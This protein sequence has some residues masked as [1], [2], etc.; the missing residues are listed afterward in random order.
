M[1]KMKMRP[2]RASES[3]L[4]IYVCVERVGLYVPVQLVW[5]YHG[6]AEGHEYNP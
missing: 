6:C 1:V 4:R 3:P 5:G 2:P